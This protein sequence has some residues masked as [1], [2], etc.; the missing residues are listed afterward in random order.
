MCVLMTSQETSYNKG[1]FTK[2]KKKTHRR[3]TLLEIF[4]SIILQ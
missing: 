1:D 4:D 3:I 2:K